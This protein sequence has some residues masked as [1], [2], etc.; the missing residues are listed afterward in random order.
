MISSSKTFFSILKENKISIE[1]MTCGEEDKISIEKIIND[2]N[3]ME[4]SELSNYFLKLEYG[5]VRFSHYMNSSSCGDFCYNI[6]SKILTK[7][8][9]NFDLM[10]AEVHQVTL[11]RYHEWYSAFE[12]GQCAANKKNGE[13]CGNGVYPPTQAKDFIP[14]EHEYCNLHSSVSNKRL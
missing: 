3:R 9:L 5:G 13:R 6:P 11:S 7:H 8:L 14:A 12:S 10:M 2:I 4:Q 1:I